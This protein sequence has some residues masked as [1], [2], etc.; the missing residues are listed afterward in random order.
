MIYHLSMYN[1]I[2]HFK[3]FVKTAPYVQ[4]TE[5][6]APHF[7]KRH[8]VFLLLRYGCCPLYLDI[9]NIF[10]IKKGLLMKQS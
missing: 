5:N 9:V 1:I 6:A 2:L 8:F 3:H 7:A 4:L 10:F